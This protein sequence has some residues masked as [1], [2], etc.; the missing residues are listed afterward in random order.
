MISQSTTSTLPPSETSNDTSLGHWRHPRV[1]LIICTLDEHEAIGGVLDEVRSVLAG[2]AHEIIVVDDSANDLTAMVVKAHMRAAPSVRLIRREGRGGLASA[3]I[4]GWDAARGRSLAI[5]DGDGQHDPKLIARLLRRMD[6]SDADVVVASR[7]LDS[8]ESGLCGPRH[9]ISRGGVVL[10]GLLLGLRLA[11][12]MSGC[13]LMRRDWYE[14]V[15][16]SLSGL[17]FKIL[18]DVVASGRRRPVVEQIPT[19]LRARAAGES[20][21]DLRVAV[22]LIT[23]LVD[24]RTGGAIPARM[25][26]FLLVGATG[27]AAHMA[28]L[29]LAAL[30]DLPFWAAQTLAILAAMSWNFVLNNSLTFRDRRLSGRALWRGLLSFYA[31][32]LGGALVSEAAGAGLASTGAPWLLAGAAGAVL[33]AFWNYQAARRLTW[34]T[35]PDAEPAEPLA[36]K[37]VVL[38]LSGE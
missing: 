14:T 32:C 16:P 13:F 26:Q 17:G 36:A 18:V 3:A 22:D 6:D 20:K 38:S 24:K 12:P 21:L 7:Y 10:S 29:S 34:R 35:S 19:V 30:T 37:P 1:S 2:V 15:R 31:A 4:A 11:D 27:L 28:V 33:G 5:M 23:L 9:L 8:A 25:S